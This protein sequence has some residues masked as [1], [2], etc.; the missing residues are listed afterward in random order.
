MNKLNTKTNLLNHSEAKVNLLGR[1]LSIYLNILSRSY[2][3]KIYLLDLFC[4]EG[5]YENGGKGSPVVILE[6]MRN[7][8]FANEKKCI[9]TEILFNDMGKSAIEPGKFKVDR[10]RDLST[11][12]FCP[13]NVN[14]H[15]TKID[16]NILIKKTIRR[17]EQLKHNERALIF[18]D[19]WGYKEINPQDIKDLIANEKTEVI[20]FLPIY[21]MS[22]F[23]EKS[24]D[25]EF[26]GGNAIRNFMTNL[27]GNINN[28]EKAFDQKDFIYKIQQKFKDFLGT[29]YVDSFK[30]ER[31]NNNWF[32]LFFF[33]NN[34]K[35][36][37]KMVESKWALDKVKGSEFRVTSI[38]MPDLFTEME[39]S[40]YDN[41]VLNFI[42][43]NYATNKTLTDFSYENNFLPTHTNAVL[44]KIK[45]KIEIV[46]LDGRN[47]R[48]FYLGNDD[49]E[50]LIKYNDNGTI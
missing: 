20:L 34:K 4:G 5:E 33:T 44:K 27:F 49:R 6:C 50:V 10:V 38:D 11:K 2:I 40:N 41:K 48:S 13:P 43:T 37:H 1:Y 39:L 28:F 32:C 30:I 8:Y 36:F 26:K 16:Y 29:N 19:P 42:K 12:I 14:M 21:F 46:P 22:R 9:S 23:V 24:R 45:D 31:E 17:T 3:D 15:F 18:I 25:E 35:G 47:A 7:H